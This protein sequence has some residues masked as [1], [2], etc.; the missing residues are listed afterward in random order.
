LFLLIGIIEGHPLDLENIN[1]G[2]DGVNI[3]YKKV[4]QICVLLIIL[5][6]TFVYITEK[7]VESRF[8]SIVDENYWVGFYGSLFGGVLG[9]IL[10]LLGV[11]L[12]IKYY[13]DQQRELNGLNVKPYLKITDRNTNVNSV[14]WVVFRIKE[15][16]KIHCYDIQYNPFTSE[17]F[18][19]TLTSYDFRIVVKNV[20]NNSAID[21]KLFNKDWSIVS[22]SRELSHLAK[23]EE[24]GIMVAIE[25]TNIGILDYIKKKRL[26][27]EENSVFREYFLTFSDIIGNN[28]VQDVN[29]VFDKKY[30]KEKFVKPEFKVRSGLPKKIY[31][32]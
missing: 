15:Y 19:D 28:Y 2:G 1:I 12:T 22:T 27:G 11:F 24:M 7:A 16:D 5:A 4:S 26:E 13:R 9:G 21:L 14:G 23:N 18:D 10:T 31:I 29:I 8:V 6:I 3:N 20:G 25:Y 30:I 32:K 17:V